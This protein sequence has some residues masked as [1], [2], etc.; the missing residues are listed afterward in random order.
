MMTGVLVVAL[1][2]FSLWFIN[3]PSAVKKKLGFFHLLL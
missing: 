3:K 1:D 2:G